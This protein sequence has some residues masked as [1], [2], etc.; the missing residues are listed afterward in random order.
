MELRQPPFFAPVAALFRTGYGLLGAVV[1]YR[2]AAHTA[3]GDDS[4]KGVFSGHSVSLSFY[5]IFGARILTVVADDIANTVRESIGVDDS[6]AY[7]GVESYL[8]KVVF[9]AVLVGAKDDGNVNVV[10]GSLPLRVGRSHG[11]A[12]GEDSNRFF[13]CLGLFGGLHAAMQEAV[14]PGIDARN[15]VV[16]PT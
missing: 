13:E 6:G 5:G 9:V 8:V 2:V 10:G 7:K 14:F 4:A 1:S 15:P 3:I 11:A 16:I 12:S